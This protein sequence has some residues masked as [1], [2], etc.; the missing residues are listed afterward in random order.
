MEF[1]FAIVNESCLSIRF[2]LSRTLAHNRVLS[3][4]IVSDNNFRSEPKALFSKGNNEIS[5]CHLN[6]AIVWVYA[7]L[8]HTLL[9]FGR[10]FSLN[11]WW[12]CFSFIARDN[13][14]CTEPT[15]NRLG[16]QRTLSL[17]HCF[18]RCLLD[19]V[20]SS[21]KND[22]PKKIF[23]KF[24]FWGVCL[25]QRRVFVSVVFQYRACSI[26]VRFVPQL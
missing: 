17:T 13:G 16:R 19:Y 1:Y 20:C 12:A 7:C 5:F 8:V 25:K 3:I 21:I 22:F 23:L 18:N 11:I 4:T 24:L 9:V 10:L 2:S 15:F 6:V 26:S 14:I